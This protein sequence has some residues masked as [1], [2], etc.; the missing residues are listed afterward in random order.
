[1]QVLGL[2]MVDRDSCM[3]LG[4]CKG[5]AGFGLCYGGHIFDRILRAAQELDS[6]GLCVLVQRKRAL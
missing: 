6:I 3:Q 5:F 2:L 1:V 4:L